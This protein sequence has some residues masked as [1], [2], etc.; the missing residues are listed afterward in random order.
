LDAL[1]QLEGASFGYGRRAVVSGVDLRVDP[2]AFVGLV[3]PNGAGKTTLFRGMLGLIPAL[4]GR[5][6]RP[7]RPMGYV[8]QKDNLDPIYPL[9]VDE[10]VRMGGLHR[11][12]GWRRIRPE[13]RR[14]AL[15]CLERV[16][17]ADRARAPFADLSGG[18]RQRVL[19]ARA[20]MV[21]PS[22][23]LLD[24]PTSGVD[25]AAQQRIVELL[26]LLHADGVAILLV[27]HQIPLLRGVV[28]RVLWV[29]RGR[30]R[31]GSP[32]EL[33][34]PERLERLFEDE[35]RSERPRARRES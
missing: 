23:L 28:E 22:L 1:L 26:R 27:S 3:G 7:D 4:T 20:L 9:R 17:L 30:V 11:L 19:V 24:E 5:V 34:D 6:L 18:Q 16:G 2:G 31:A 12:Q 10:V 21:R 8:P 14:L 13:E 33:L 35:A 25:Q 15:E 32:Q 29:E